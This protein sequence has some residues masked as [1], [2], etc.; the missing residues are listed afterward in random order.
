MATK[1][2]P[3]NAVS[4][5]AYAVYVFD[6]PVIAQASPNLPSFHRD[7]FSE[8]GL[9]E[10]LNNRIPDVRN[11]ATGAIFKLHSGMC[12]LMAKFLCSNGIHW[13]HMPRIIRATIAGDNEFFHLPYFGRDAWLA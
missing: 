4:D 12:Q 11:A 10:R 3:T 13:I 7:I 2:T 1:F 8:L 6:L 5:V 9:E